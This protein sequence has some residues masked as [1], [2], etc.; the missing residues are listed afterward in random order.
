MS[1][2]AEKPLPWPPRKEDLERLYLVQKLTAAKIARVYGLKHKNDKVA[3]STVLHHLKRNGIRRRDPAEH[4]RKVSEAT[5]DEWVVKYL[6]G[7]SLKQIA[8][9]VVDP[10]TVWNHPK[11]RGVV[12]RDK[13]EAQIQA[14]SKY[15]RKP[16][17][18]DTIEQAYLMGLRYGDLNA[19]RHG[20]AIRVRVSTTHP[21][22]A[23]LFESVFAPYGHVHR[24]A[25]RAKLVAYEC[26]LECDLDSSFEF[27][28]RKPTVTQLE[29]LS[30]DETVSFLAG[31]FDS[32]GSI[33]L[34]C[35]RGRYSPEA[36]ISNTDASILGFV[37]AAVTRLG[38][39]CKLSWI[40]QS[41]DRAGVTGKSSKGQA[42]V[43]R[44][45]DVQRLFRLVPI[46]HRE[47]IGKVGIVARMSYRG[48]SSENKAI[49]SLWNDLALR[50]RED[51]ARFVHQ[52]SEAVENRDMWAG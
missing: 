3:E 20:R 44:F 18:G 35:K 17:G 31:L 38:L 11:A 27:L 41:E 5:V 16:F 7:R 12:Q 50:I 22:M 23:D 9:D 52:A 49:A 47:K 29:A 42:T 21:A 46:R 39:H 30:R 40:A 48:S 32:E 2:A 45:M 8:E 51:R 13:V 4:F 34:H 36:S 37:E 6:T 10:V 14:A 28:L 1:A 19:V 25:R 24:Y 43:W 26:S 33:F 15:E